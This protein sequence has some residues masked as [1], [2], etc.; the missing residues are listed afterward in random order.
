MT[1][2]PL[3][4]MRR[5]EKEGYK[6]AECNSRLIV[7]W[8]DGWRLR[9]VNNINHKGVTRHDK[10]QEEI[11][12]IIRKE[13]H[14]DSTALT[15][16]SEKDMVERIGRAKFPQQ[17]SQ[18]EV[19][20]LAVAARSY[21]F[22]PLMGEISIFQGRP[23][24]SIDGRYR[25]A[26]ETGLLDGVECRPASKQEREDWQI[27]EGDFFFRAEV[28]V[29]GASKLFVGWG[30]VRASELTE[31]SKRDPSRLASP[32]VAANPQRMAEKRAEAQALRKAFHIPLPSLEDIGTPDAEPCADGPEVIEAEVE[33]LSTK[34]QRS[35]IFAAAKEMQVTED[36]LKKYI[37]SRYQV[38]HTTDLTKKQASE[39]IDAIN[40]GNLPLLEADPNK[41]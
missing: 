32:V 1:T 5:Y 25:K 28:Y 38:E 11:K 40:T 9:C 18:A 30:R 12:A 29:K 16:M 41:S 6:C 22:D 21:G 36:Y 27:P 31:K 15:L 10:A 33:E 7:V 37:A 39:L 13:T 2:L 17:L 14:M 35:T 20:T 4:E 24:V 26:Q 19:R 34:A 8:M 23:F 3:S